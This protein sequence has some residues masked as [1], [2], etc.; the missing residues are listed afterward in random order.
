MKSWT[1]FCCT[2]LLPRLQ[3]P[4]L[5]LQAPLPGPAH[6]D[7][8]L[9]LADVDKEMFGFGRSLNPETVGRRLHVDELPVLAKRLA[10]LFRSLAHLQS[11]D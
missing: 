5:H 4:T 6:H 9:P 2:A 8:Q 3:L 10:G 7:E 11:V 1:C